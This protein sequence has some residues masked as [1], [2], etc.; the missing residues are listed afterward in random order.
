MSAS[1]TPSGDPISDRATPCPVSAPPSDAPEVIELS[2]DQ[3]RNR[4]VQAE[5]IQAVQAVPAAHHT[6]APAAQRF[7]APLQ[8]LPR[9]RPPKPK[10]LQIIIPPHVWQQNSPT[11]SSRNP[12]LASAA[13]IVQQPPDRKPPPEPSYLRGGY[14]LGGFNPSRYSG[15]SAAHPKFNAD[16]RLVL[17]HGPNSLQAWTQQTHHIARALS[18]FD[19]L[20]RR[21]A[22][23][24]PASSVQLF[25]CET[26][27]A[28]A[29]RVLEASVS[30]QVW[31]YMRVL[32]LSSIPPNGEGLMSP[33]PADCYEYAILAATNIFVPGTLEQPTGERKRMVQ[34]I[35]T[36]QVSDYPSER[37]Y[38]KGITWL[39][40]ACDNLIRHGDFELAQSLYEPLPDWA[41]RP[42]DCE[43]PGAPAANPGDAEYPEQSVDIGEAQNPSISA[44]NTEVAN[45]LASYDASSTPSVSQ[46]LKLVPEGQKSTK[47]KRARKDE[48]LQ[49]AKA[50]ETL[51][52]P[53][54]R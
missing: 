32:G 44:K 40:M 42:P 2:P 9:G 34:E 48:G 17:L 4:P 27:F 11:A 14:L 46:P 23:F 8:P 19:E 30:G 28:T 53:D 20:T 24:P 1:G 50:S 52:A 7:I 51:M 31:A 26:R 22:S 54:R 3:E 10:A 25:I 38:K 15:V 43:E 35:L 33:T 41:P 29:F 21:F 37:V 12:P 45:G 36:A 13:P 16:G 6:Y 47:R 49:P 18:C 39:R 5:P